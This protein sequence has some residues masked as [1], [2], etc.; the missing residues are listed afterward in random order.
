V[1]LKPDDKP[2]GPAAPEAAPGPL[3]RDAYEALAERYAAMADAGCGPGFYAGWLAERGAYVTAFD[4]SPAMVRL[5]RER[6]QSHATVVEA[7]LEQPLDFV[8]TAT[9]DLVVSGLALDYARDWAAVFREFHRT[10]RPGGHLVF[11]SSHPL[12][13][14]QIHGA[15][16]Y[17]RTERLTTVWSG[18]GVRVQ[19]PSYRRPLAAI[20]NPLLEV[21]FALDRLVEPKP[22]EEFRRVS[23]DEHRTLSRRPG[24]LCVR[25][26]KPA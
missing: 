10:L 20:L 18:F 17:F 24:F 4:V 11:S 8:Q 26:V 6:L 22:T 23:P 1:N 9:F 5:A 2:L 19:V 7:D 12:A 13:D 25:A 16:S 15:G 3:A 14:F 21:G